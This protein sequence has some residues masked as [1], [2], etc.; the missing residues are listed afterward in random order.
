M[1]AV[2][3]VTPCYAEILRPSDRVHAR[4]VLEELGDFVHEIRGRCCGQPGFNSGNQREAAQAGKELLR[5]AHEFDTV[6]TPSGSC[7]S[8]VRHA[9][10]ELFAGR[11]RDGAGRI[12]ARFVEF[13]AYVSGHQQVEQLSLNLD[14]TVA[15]HDSCHARRDLGLTD[16][17]FSLLAR[18]D[19]LEVRRLEMEAVCCG[20]GGAFSVK[21]AEVSEAIRTLKLDDVAGTGAQ[22]LVSTDLSCLSHVATGARSAGLALETWT[23]AEL[24]AEALE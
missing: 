11:L 23:I 17:V 6:V 22:I 18:I 2:A 24:L 19:G 16:S 7:T 5:A 15:Y 9:L 1:A 20:F 4:R 21:H 8:M 14:A 3:L 13:S 10:P 12:S